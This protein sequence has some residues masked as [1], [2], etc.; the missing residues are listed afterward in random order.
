MDYNVRVLNKSE[1]DYKEVFRGEHIIIPAGKCI[2]MDYDKAVTFLGTM[3]G[4]KVDKHGLQDPRSCKNLCIVSEDKVRIIEQRSGKSPDKKDAEGFSVFVCHACSKEFRTKN[5]LLKHIK[6]NHANL[7]VDDDA[8][9]ELLD[10]EEVD[11]AE[12]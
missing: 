12:S 5:G 11:N 9:D 6:L 8:R 3:G 10:D 1:Y 2:V 7:M 4:F